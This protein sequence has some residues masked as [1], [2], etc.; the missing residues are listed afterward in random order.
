V[1][2]AVA[3][4][5]ATALGLPLTDADRRRIERVP[6]AN[7]EAYDLY[8]RSTGLSSVRRTENLAGI[9][10]LQQAVRRDSTFA[11]AYAT[12]ARRFVFQAYLVDPVFGDSAGVAV[13]RAL[14]ADSGLGE[15]WFAEGDLQNFTGHPS[16]ARLSFLK[17][18]DRDPGHLPAMVNLADVDASLGRFDESLVW[19]ARAAR[20]DPDR[21][22][23]RFHM[24]T[25][26]YYL[27]A[28]DAAERS[29]LD[30]GRR[31]PDYERFPI[32]LARLDFVRGRDSAALERLR[33]YVERDPGNEEAAVALA[34]F[35]ALTGAPDGERLVEERMRASPGATP[36]GPAKV[37]FQGLL[38]LT[39]R[40]RG[41]LASARMLEASVLRAARA[42]EAEGREELTFATERAALHAVRGDAEAFRWLE[43]AYAAGERDYRWLAVDPFFAPFRGDARFQRILARM[44]ADVAAMRRRATDADGGAF[45]P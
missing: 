37:S 40:R 13:R 8:L 11:F 38:A 10:L 31:W 39:R 27:A 33:R 6:T 16:A 23:F 22:G 43:R 42:R 2:A 26:L 25:A 44:E 32:G 14:A 45:H 15:A 21:P 18:L 20:Q 9:A 35:A 19:A 1:H 3:G 5:V 17:A 34:A 30:A 12:L 41:D 29:M 7:A 4:D 24:V 28:D 36:Y